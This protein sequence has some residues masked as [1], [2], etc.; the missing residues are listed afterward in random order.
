MNTT[1]PVVS[2]RLRLAFPRDVPLGAEAHVVVP[3]ARRRAW[4][5]FWSRVRSRLDARTLSIAAAT[6]VATFS[7]GSAGYVHAKAALAQVMLRDAFARTLADGAPARPWPW[8]DTFP[9]ARLQVASLG[10][11]QIVLAGASGRTLA[12]G[13][14]HLDGSV[15]PGASGNSVIVAHRDTHFRFLQHVGAGDAL[16]VEGR[17]GAHRHF[18]VRRSYIADFRKLDIPRDTAVPTLTLVTCYPFDA[19]NPGGPLRY[20]VVAEAG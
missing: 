5:E 14:G 18:R 15:I 3:L 17:D 20:V 4:R 1:N 19:I 16:I 7:L 13:P 11:D 9:A 12:F 8:A 6:V 10:I 2:R